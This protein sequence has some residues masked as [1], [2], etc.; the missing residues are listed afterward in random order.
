M[1]TINEAYKHLKEQKNIEQNYKKI[2]LWWDNL[3]ITKQ[4]NLFWKYKGIKNINV[5]QFINDYDKFRIYNQVH[6]L[7]N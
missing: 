3:P 5:K 7:N 1:K 4:Q 2:I 6:E